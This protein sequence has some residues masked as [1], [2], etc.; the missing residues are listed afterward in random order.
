M[1]IVPTAIVDHL[2]M[3]FRLAPDDMRGKDQNLILSFDWNHRLSKNFPALSKVDPGENTT[4]DN[5]LEKEYKV[6]QNLWSQDIV[7]L[8]G[9]VMDN[10]CIT[11]LLFERCDRSLEDRLQEQS[12]GNRM[13]IR[14]RLRVLKDLLMGL[15]CAQQK[16]IVHCDI[17]PD[18]ILLKNHKGR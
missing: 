1:Q 4:G 6:G 12:N 16:G 14:E 9:W 5:S 17:K 8:M 10:A 18:N 15:T 3:H 11:G 13:S 7:Q 2:V